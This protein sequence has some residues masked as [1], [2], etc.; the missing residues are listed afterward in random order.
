[1]ALHKEYVKTIIGKKQILFSL[2]AESCS[3]NCKSSRKRK[4]CSVVRKKRFNEL[5][6]GCVILQAI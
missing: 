3:Y 1:M 2:N 4:I 6:V 5:A